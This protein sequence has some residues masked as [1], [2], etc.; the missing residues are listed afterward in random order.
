MF[1]EL[2]IRRWRRIKA[3]LFTTLIKTEFK[4]FG[5]R[6]RVIPPFRFANLKEIV[7]E[8]GVLIDRDC[9]LLVLDCSFKKDQPKLLIRERCS[10]GMGS[11]ISAVER[12]EI[13][14]HVL[15]ARNVYISD[16]SHAFEGLDKPIMY[17]GIYSIKPVRIGEGTWIGQ[18]ACIL[19]GADIGAHC[20]IGANSVVRSAIPDFCVGV[21][22][23]ARV[24]KRF[25]Q[26][27]QCW[28]KL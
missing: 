1:I 17:Q 23:P 2:A 24:V 18:N 12:I 20:V 22:S 8:S 14:K 15:F 5:P 9:W 3:Q 16:H 21:G 27:R 11:T 10:I 13:G 6:S 4:E 25:S 7:V 19:P 26:E 28:E